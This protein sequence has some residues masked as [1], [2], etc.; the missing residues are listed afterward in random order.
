MNNYPF[1]PLGVQDM[2]AALYALTDTQLELVAQLIETD[3]GAWVTNTFQL[4]PSQLLYLDGMNATFLQSLG[5]RT[6]LAVRH[7]LPLVV[8]IWRNARMGRDSMK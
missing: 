5:Q 2:Q 8:M 3:F 6:A 4:D 7:R 1:T